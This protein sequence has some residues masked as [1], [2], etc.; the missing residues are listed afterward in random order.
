MKPK[1]TAKISSNWK[2]LSKII[3]ESAPAKPISK[4]FSSDSDSDLEVAPKPQNNFTS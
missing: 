1:E 2:A 3:K 4:P